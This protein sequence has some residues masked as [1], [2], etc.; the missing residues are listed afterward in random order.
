[1]KVLFLFLFE[2][3]QK[4]QEL[5]FCVQINSNK[6]FNFWLVFFKFVNFSNYNYKYKKYLNNIV[7]PKI[8]RFSLLLNVTV[9][10]FL[11]IPLFPLHG[12]MGG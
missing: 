2:C 9:D 10:T 5:R 12:S 3:L 6:F 7:F 8:Q 11:S 4:I 1:M